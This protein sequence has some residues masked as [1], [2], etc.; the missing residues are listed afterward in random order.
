V[1][2]TGRRSPLFNAAYTKIQSASGWRS[3]E[4][5]CGH[6]VMIDMPERLVEVLL[7]A[8]SKR[9]YFGERAK[10]AADPDG[11]ID[12]SHRAHWAPADLPVDQDAGATIRAAAK[13]VVRYRPAFVRKTTFRG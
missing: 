12:A 7:E 10:S 5:P 9:Q 1:L 13:T 11:R 4:V 2:A 6:F 8:W 3:Y